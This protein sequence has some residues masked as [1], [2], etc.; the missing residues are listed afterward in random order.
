MEY[1]Y[2]C[3]WLETPLAPATASGTAARFWWGRPRW[4]NA[5]AVA[6]AVVVLAA[7]A[8]AV[9]AAA[10]VLVAAAAA[11]LLVAV[12]A[13][14]PAAAS[15][16]AAWRRR[17][18]AA[19]QPQAGL[20]WKIVIALF[21]AN[22]LINSARKLARELITCSKASLSAFVFL[23]ILRPAFEFPIKVLRMKQFSQG[24]KFTLH[25][26]NTFW[27]FFLMNMSLSLGPFLP[28]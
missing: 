10:G 23:C 1:Y 18:F 20:C 6:V 3:T 27:S 28:E 15:P 5:V 12:A 9:V 4:M 8:A 21:F 17:W 14:W 7:A 16:R 11:A 24:F 22:H 26:L 13:A 25:T 19:L 2:C